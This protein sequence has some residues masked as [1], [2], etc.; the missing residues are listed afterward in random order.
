MHQELTEKLYQDFPELY[1]GKGKSMK[2]S[3]MCWGFS[4]GDGWFMIIY[5]LSAD[6]MDIC[7]RDG[8]DIPEVMQVKEKFGGLCYYIQ[9]AN[10]AIRERISE[11]RDAAS[12][13]C[14]ACGEPGEMRSNN[15]CVQTL[16]DEHFK[17][18]V[19]GGA[20]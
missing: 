9:G 13:T 8:I 16:C 1:R 20:F 5:E 12:K 3:C 2:E 17:R 19:S 14:E 10:D 11:A 6:I 7:K 15:G 18:P 4:H